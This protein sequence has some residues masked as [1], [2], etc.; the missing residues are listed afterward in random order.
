MVE[1]VLNIRDEHGNNFLHYV[2]ESDN[3]E[4]LKAAID[5]KSV[6]PVEIDWNVKHEASG[7]YWI[8]AALKK[9]SLEIFKFLS[10]IP[11]IDWKVT[12]ENGA[13]LEEVA[14]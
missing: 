9:N 6:E 7:Y 13:T 4:L 12:D 2:L 5:Y 8:M 14:R 1:F 3:S 11:S 10:T